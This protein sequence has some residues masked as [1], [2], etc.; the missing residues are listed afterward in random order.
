MQLVF[1]LVRKYPFGEDSVGTHSGF[2]SFTWLQWADLS[3][4]VD[5]VLPCPPQWTFV[6]VG[7]IAEPLQRLQG[8]LQTWR[9]SDHPHTLTF[10]ESTLRPAGRAMNPIRENN[11]SRMDF[12]WINASILVLGRSSDRA[13][14][15]S[16]WMFIKALLSHGKAGILASFTG[17]EHLK[18]FRLRLVYF[19]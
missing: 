17:S 9:G 11:W 18:L 5:I 8:S 19:R 2:R 16:V 3:R 6:A 14:C 15:C 4:N 7:T 12:P 13:L 1:Y 10:T